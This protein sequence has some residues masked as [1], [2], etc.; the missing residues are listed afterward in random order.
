MIQKS[1]ESNLFAQV[2][3][4]KLQVTSYKLQVTSNKVQVTSYNPTC[5]H[6]RRIQIRARRSFA[7]N[8]LPA[9]KSKKIKFE[10]LSLFVALKLTTLEEY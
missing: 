10:M 2:T 1:I 4:Y 9:P 7:Q 8:S 5:L 6:I 3:S